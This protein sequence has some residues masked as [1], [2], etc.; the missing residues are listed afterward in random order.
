MRKKITL[1]FIAYLAASWALPVRAIEPSLAETDIPL[2]YKVRAAYLYNFA[3][4]I[5][6]PEKAF[7]SPEDPIVVGVAG[8]DNFAAVLPAALRDLQ[9]EGRSIVVKRLGPDD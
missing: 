2:E 1:T 5:D 4:F 8:H 9:V 6:W 7:A 3:R